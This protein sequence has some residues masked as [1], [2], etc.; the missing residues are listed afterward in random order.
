MVGNAIYINSG[1]NKMCKVTT[2]T[3]SEV[4]IGTDGVYVLADDLA[5]WPALEVLKPYMDPMRERVGRACTQVLPGSPLHTFFPLR[6][7]NESPVGSDGAAQMLLARMLFTFCA[8]H[9]AL[10]PLLFHSGDQN[11]A[12]STFFELWRALLKNGKE[13]GLDA[14]TSAM[15]AFIAAVAHS[16]YAMFDNVDRVDFE[17]R[18]NK[19]YAD[20]ICNLAYGAVETRRKLYS[21]GKP[22][23]LKIKTHCFLT[24]RVYP[25]NHAPDA[26]RRIIHLTMAPGPRPDPTKDQGRSTKGRP[27]QSH[28][29][30]L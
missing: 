15:D 22:V 9:Y 17:A 8:N 5:P 4:L 26:M 13:D 7:S 27:R 21:D 1:D 3:I 14:F 29:D 20:K 24:A 19:T 12:K 23:K 10:W 2:D 11:S 28:S 30:P 25:F 6:Y 18:E 16:S